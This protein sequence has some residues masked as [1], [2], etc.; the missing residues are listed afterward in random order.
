VNITNQPAFG[1]GINVCDNYIT[2]WNSSVTQGEYAPVP[3]KGT[4]KIVPPY[5]PT[6][7]TL[8][9]WGYR[10]DNSFIE[11][12]NV[13]CEDLQGYAGTGPGDSE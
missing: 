8:D 4:V 12:N 9:A 1:S 10:M 5:Y 7:T 6:P 3:V 13:K 11:N 2:L